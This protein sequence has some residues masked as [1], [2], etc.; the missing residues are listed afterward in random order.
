MELKQVSREEVKR[1]FLLANAGKELF[2]E[3]IELEERYNQLIERYGNFSEREL[4]ELIS[5]KVRL[6]RYENMD[7]YCSNAHLEEMGVWPKMQGLDI[8][9]TTGNV[10]ST[11]NGIQKVIDGNSN[12]IVPK[13]FLNK[14]YSIREHS[15]FLFSRFKPILFPGG[16]VRENDYNNWAREN[17]EPLC[18]VFRYDIDDGNSRI[19]SYAL[20]GIERTP[21]YIGRRD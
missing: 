2:K 9:L 5:D 1:A 12:L 17:N 15:D 8:N 3:E 18:K 20:D 14:S 21:V 4:N 10:I 13:R 11:I 6:K 7:W 16:E 19:V